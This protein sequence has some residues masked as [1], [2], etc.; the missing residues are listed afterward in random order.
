MKPYQRGRITL[1]KVAV[2][3]ITD[4]LMQL[5]QILCLGVNRTAN[6]VG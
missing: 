5:L 3:G 6:G 2:H 1:L 4:L